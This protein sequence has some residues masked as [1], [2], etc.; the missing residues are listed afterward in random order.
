MSTGRSEPYA[1]AGRFA[2]G[3]LAKVLRTGELILFPGRSE[4]SSLQ[5]ATR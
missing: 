1:Q 5:G 2:D 4:D 3:D